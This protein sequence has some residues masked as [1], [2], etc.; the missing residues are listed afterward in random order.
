MMEQL[1]HLKLV[2]LINVVANENTARIIELVV[3]K[4]STNMENNQTNH[5]DSDNQT[6]NNIE[7]ENTTTDNTDKDTS[8]I[9]DISTK[10]SQSN[11]NK[12]TEKA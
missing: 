6:S 5:V 12:E 9:S 4:D 2:L 7:Q 10:L 8:N 1:K 3:I 11:Q